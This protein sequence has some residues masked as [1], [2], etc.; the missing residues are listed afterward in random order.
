V[1]LGIEREPEC[2]LVHVPDDTGLTLTVLS[3]EPGSPSEEKLAL[4]ASWSATLDQVQST[5]A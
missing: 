5:A 1:A 2:A 3:A 4:L